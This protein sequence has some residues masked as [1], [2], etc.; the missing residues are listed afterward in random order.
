MKHREKYQ[1]IVVGAG[2]AGIEASLAA[3]RCGSRVALVTLSKNSIARMS[4]NP[5]I[6]GLAKGQMV[7]EIDSLGGVMGVAAD[8]SGIQFKMLNRSKGRAVWSPRAQVDKRKYEK[9]VTM[10]MFKNPLIDIIEAE[11]VSTV[12]AKGKITGVKTVDNSIIN[13]GSVVLTNGTFLNGLIHIGNK[14]IPA[15]RMGESRSVGITESLERLGLKH[16]RLKTG[17]PPRLFG[18]SVD[19]KKLEKIYGDDNP[20]P[21]SHYHKEFSPPNMPCYTVLTNNS[22]HDIISDNL[23]RSPMYSGDIGGVG[24]RYCPSIEDKIDRFKDKSSHRLICEPEWAGS[25]QIYLN[26]FSTSLPEEVQRSSLQ[27]LPGFEN[28]EFVRPGYAIE[29][30][31]I[32]PY[33]LKRT[34]ESKVV[35]GLYLAGQIN[36]TSGYEEA[37]IQ[38]LIAGANASLCLRGK[39]GALVLGRSDA[40][41]GVLID[42]L[43]TKS[44]PEPYRMFTSRAEHRLVLRYTNANRRLGVKAHSCGLIDEK[45]LSILNKQIM[46]TDKAVFE[47]KVSVDP[48]RVNKK[49]LSCGG[50]PIVQKMPLKTLLKRPCVLLADFEG[51]FISAPFVSDPYKDEVL[52]E[53]DTLIKYNGYIKRSNKH[54]KKIK[55]S[56]AVKLSPQLDYPSIDGLSTE[57]KEKLF[58]MKPETLGQA[59]RISGVTPAD[60]SVLTVFVSRQERVSRET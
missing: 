8:F 9:Y 46:A 15:G 24:P 48:A 6:G 23:M 27:C 10:L 14:K 43:I 38:G 11:V 40:Y 37:A 3:A 19:W 21:F 1:V 33:Q 28:V 5:S 17:T 42:D 34:L 45:M 32:F 39:G 50:A 13:A 18:K 29:Y 31:Y 55:T 59:M 52:L 60:I 30:D 49:L 35:P 7:R 51:V 20:A 22:A 26:G 54:I 2:H 56:E 53:A 25:D 36:G 41:A 44:T 12:V 58:A 16:G 57:S 4:C 47:S